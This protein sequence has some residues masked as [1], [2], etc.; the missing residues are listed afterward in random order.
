M[1]AQSKKPAARSIEQLLSENEELIRRLKEAD[2]T[3]H[4]IRDNEVDALIVSD[5][6]YTL[7]SAERPYRLL[8]EQ[9][10]EG[11]LTV[12]ADGLILYCNPRF[13]QMVKTPHEKTVGAVLRSF[14]PEQHVELLESVLWAGARENVKCEINLLA[15]DGATIPVIL[16]IGPLPSEGEGHVCI[17]ATDLT[18]Q[19]RT[20][21]I[22]AAEQLA[23]SILENAA[24]AIVVCDEKG[25]IIRANQAA[26]NLCGQKLMDQPF[27][28]VFPLESESDVPEAPE[29]SPKN[30]L[31]ISEALRGKTITGLSGRLPLKNG[32]VVYV[33]ISAGPL[34]GKDGQVIGCVITLTDITER[35]QLMTELQQAMEA[36]HRIAESLQRSL[37]LKPT[38]NQFP[39]LEVEPNYKAALDEAQLGGDFFDAFALSDGK[40]ALVIGDVS[41]KGLVAAT[42]TAEIKFTLRAYLREDAN[43]VRALSRLNV[44]LCG[45]QELDTRPVLN[46]VCLMLAVLDPA[47]KKAVFTGA[48]MEPPL[49]MRANGET[50]E[51]P[52][53]GV[54]LSIDPNAQYTAIESRFS[55]RDIILM[56]TDGITEA[57]RDRALFGYKRLVGLM[58][59]LYPLESLEQIAQ[60]IFEHVRTYAGGRLQ[61]DACLLLTRFL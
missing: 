19:K 54:P 33:L 43:P 35:R 34:F 56:V 17:V 40:V 45:A 46:F 12:S 58:K 55:S 10:Q 8:I 49:I 14:V 48:G 60:I 23:R 9:M 3:L 2:D 15:A 61:D 26:C 18:E 4:A 53:T 28:K 39:G 44:F 16:T 27:A 1:D 6:V 30:G 59:Q 37:L 36:D 24:E 41:G 29:D 42:R 52:L 25:I 38:R 7:Q 32:G 51:L 11:A 57:R 21:E 22:I 5:Q 20:R 13:S 47:A 31:S 50:E